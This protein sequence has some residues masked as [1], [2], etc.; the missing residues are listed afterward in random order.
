MDKK[1][2]IKKALKEVLGLVP[3]LPIAATVVS[4]ENQTCTIKLHNGF[5]LSDVRLKSTITSGTDGLL[6]IPKINSEV[7]VLSQTGELSGL[8]L[9]KIDRAEKII[10]KEG[11]FQ[12]EL[13][14][15]TKKVTIKN[16]SANLGNL[17]SD[18]ISTISS[19]QIITPNGPGTINP[20]TQGQLNVISNKFKTILNSN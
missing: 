13:N 14:A 10:Y 19:A 9:I 7:L 12:F 18:L 8:M 5:K 3:N 11:D 6:V 2:Q 1:A 15:T 4:V 17:I 20:A 16:Q